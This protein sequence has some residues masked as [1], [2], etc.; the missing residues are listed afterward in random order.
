MAALRQGN[1]KDVTIFEIRALSLS[2]LAQPLLQETHAM[3]SANIPTPF[4]H[5]LLP[6]RNIPF[7]LLQQALK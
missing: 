4:F 6:E 2:N 7:F 3:H 5:N 1:S